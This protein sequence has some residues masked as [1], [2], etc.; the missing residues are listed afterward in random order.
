MEAILSELRSAGS[1]DSTGAFSIDLRHGLEKLGRYQL[2]DKNR[3]GL[4]LMATAFRRAATEVIIRNDADDFI[5]SWPGEPLSRAELE[6]LFRLDGALLPLGLALLSAQSLKPLY[7]RVDSGPLRLELKSGKMRLLDVPDFPGVRVHVRER[8]SWRTFAKYALERLQRP[9]ESAL[10]VQHCG[11]LGWPIQVNGKAIPAQLDAGDSWLVLKLRGRAGH[12]PLDAVAPSRNDQ[13]LERELEGDYSAVVLLGSPRRRGL[14]VVAQGLRFPQPDSLSPDLFVAMLVVRPEQRIDISYSR[15][16]ADDALMEALATVQNATDEVLGEVLPTAPPELLSAIG[17]R[18]LRRGLRSLWLRVQAR[19][20]LG[21]RGQQ[22]YQLMTQLVSAMPERA[23]EPEWQ[24]ALRVI[25]TRL[26]HERQS[27]V[28]TVSEVSTQILNLQIL[29]NLRPEPELLRAIRLEEGFLLAALG[30]LPL[31]EQ[32]LESVADAHLGLVVLL[33]HRDPRWLPTT[34]LANGL[35]A[36]LQDR[37]A[38][39][40]EHLARAPVSPVVLDLRARLEALGGQ[41]ESAERLNQEAIRGSQGLML[42]LREAFAS[43]LRS[44]RLDHPLP[45]PGDLT[46]QLAADRAERGIALYSHL[47]KATMAFMQQTLAGLGDSDVVRTAVTQ[48]GAVQ[49]Y[50]RAA[51]WTVGDRRLALGQRPQGFELMLLVELTA[52]WPLVE[53]A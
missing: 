37:L 15:L 11:G 16:H 48:L 30:R 12:G 27:R 9:P 7:I 25:L 31:A 36:L 14:T 44:R 6:D 49:P 32:A 47:D 26:Q 41:W 46:E 40:R 45:P 50:A 4:L 21:N 39:A 5:L 18:M 51:A 2:L 53:G 10:I 3:Y 34:P 33:R 43:A 13:V 35:T 24:D 42:R 20:L 28:Q 29:A 22:L 8:Y 1:H 38:E 52:L 23:P 17:A 19:L